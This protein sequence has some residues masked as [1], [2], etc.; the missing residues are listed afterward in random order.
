MLWIV[1]LR[2]TPSRMCVGKAAPTSLPPALQGQGLR[3]LRARR[4]DPPPPGRPRASW[5]VRKSGPGRVG[6]LLSPAMSAPPKVPCQKSCTPRLVWWTKLLARARWR[7]KERATSL[8]K[9][10]GHVKARKVS[11]QLAGW[12]QTRALRLPWIHGSPRVASAALPPTAFQPL[13]RPG[14]LSWFHPLPRQCIPA[15]G[16][17]MQSL[18]L[19]L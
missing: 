19:L 7:N 10:E 5:L 3:V 17:Y 16:S 6:Q 14:T 15:P 4:L 12:L 1:G 18:P 8:G 11:T 9:G 13:L 2:W